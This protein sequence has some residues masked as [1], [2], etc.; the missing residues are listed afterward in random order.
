[1]KRADMNRFRDRLAALATRLQ[2]T[3][4]AAE[5][6]A[7][8]STGGEAAGDLSNTPIHLADIGS[9]ESAQ[10]IG[11]TLLENEQYLQ[12]EISAALD[13]IEDGSY[14]RCENC[15]RSIPRSR[16]EAVPYTRY[17][18]A[19]AKKLDAG[20]P[21]NLNEGRPAS[22]AAGIGLRAQGPP[23][24]APGGPEEVAPRTDRH[25]V[26]TPGGGTAIG[27]LAGTNVGEGAPEGSD[28]EEAMGSGD[29][30]SSMDSASPTT[31]QT[32]EE[33]TGGY[34]GHGGGAVG[35]TPANKRASGGRRRP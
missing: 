16:L 31:P 30:D 17:C 32:D 1:M 11:A 22:W 15:N 6:Q 4:I 5:D 8:M 18:I 34:S 7:R 3:R 28:L 25:A 9:E 26:G 23:E 35:G 27:G 20:R 21:V 19:C 14:G 2:A 33:P 29:F 24:G 12:G 13:R 10:E